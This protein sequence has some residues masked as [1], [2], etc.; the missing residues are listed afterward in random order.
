MLSCITDGTSCKEVF[1]KGLEYVRQNRPDLENHLTRN[2]GFGIGL[3]FRDSEFLL[4]AKNDNILLS[5][6]TLNVAIGFQ[7]LVNKNATDEKGGK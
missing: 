4:N 1:L 2:F 3:E 6:M 5:G 7:D